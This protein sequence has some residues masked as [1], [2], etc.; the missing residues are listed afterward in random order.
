VI[1]DEKFFR[2]STNASTVSLKSKHTISMQHLE[3]ESDILF[4]KYIASSQMLPAIKKSGEDMISKL[5]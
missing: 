5:E 1:S 4:S 2:K 3:E